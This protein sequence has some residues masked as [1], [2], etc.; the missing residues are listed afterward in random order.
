MRFKNKQKDEVESWTIATYVFLALF[1]L[2]V[3]LIAALCFAQSCDRGSAVYN[4]Y[5]GPH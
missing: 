5:N 4:A 3:A 1:L 2:M